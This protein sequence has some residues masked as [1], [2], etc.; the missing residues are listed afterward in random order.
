A[1]GAVILSEIN[2][3]MLTRELAG[4]EYVACMIYRYPSSVDRRLLGDAFCPQDV[5][6]SIVFRDKCAASCDRV[7][8][9]KGSCVLEGPPYESISGCIGCQSRSAVI[10]RAASLPHPFESCACGWRICVY[11]RRHNRETMKRSRCIRH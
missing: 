6:V 4:A 7:A 2:V 10:S 3:I 11:F 8:R 1:A 9:N 5:A